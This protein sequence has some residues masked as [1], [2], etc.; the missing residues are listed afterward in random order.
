ML[1]QQSF[2]RVRRTR[3]IAILRGN[4]QGHE[5]EIAEALVDG[6]VTALEVSA[7]TQDFAL[8]LARLTA[9]FGERA[10]IGV[11]TV[12]RSEELSVAQHAGAEF[13]VSP[14]TDPEII[15]QTR[16]YGMASFPGAYTPSEIVL[17]MKSGADA[18]KIFPAVS[19]GPNYVK[20]LRGPLP[21]ALL[22]PTGGIDLQNIGEYLAA[23][24][25]AVGIGSELVGK[26]EMEHPNYDQLLAKAR[27]Y[28]Q[29]AQGTVHV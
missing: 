5:I 28:A 8:I 18:V 6:G 21:Q 27:A 23:G 16:K 26:Q 10:S 2:A 12:L 17:A 19:L 24:A 15:A 7:V 29:A 13:V 1:V 20:A 22:I 25:F 9:H 4:M 11:G 14:N 3:I